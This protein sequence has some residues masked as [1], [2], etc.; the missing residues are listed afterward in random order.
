[1]NN[2]Y[3]WVFHNGVSIIKVTGTLDKL[4][5]WSRCLE[6]EHTPSCELVG[7]VFHD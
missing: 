5:W 6:A 2:K 3:I 7:V 1:M 4:A